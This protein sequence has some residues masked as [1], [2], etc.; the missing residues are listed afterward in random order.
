MRLKISIVILNFNGW[1]D[2]L[3]CIKSLDSTLMSEFFDVSLIVIDNNSENESVLEIDQYLSKQ[4]KES[5][6]LTDDY[7]KAFDCKIV[8][9]KSSQ[10]LGFSAGNNIGIRIAKI[11]AS[12]YVMLLNNDTVVEDG[13]LNPMVQMMEENPML[14]MVGPKIFDYFN[15]S[16]YT[17]GG[18]YNKYK[19]S[20]YSFYNT[21]KADRKQLNYLSGCCWLI[22]S[23]AFEKCGL[24]DESF[25]LYVEDV[26]YSCTFI[27]NGY[28]LSCTK[29]SVIYHKEG[30][31]TSIKESLFYYNTR[32]RLYLN[33]KLGYPFYINWIFYSYL[34]ATR[35]FYYIKY[36]RLRPYLKRAVKD[37]KNCKYGKIEMGCVS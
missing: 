30:R 29:D 6:I 35:F 5:N 13:F 28:R 17:L 26:D 3:E 1:E 14:G 8:L 10:N 25:F 12:D 9:F 24:M 20:G 23:K 31:S 15:R 37:N 19:G 4:F 32:N 11:K 2:T 7:S 18:Y 22:R 16:E 36:P 21:E 33:K 27:N 34:F